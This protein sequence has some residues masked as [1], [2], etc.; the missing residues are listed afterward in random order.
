MNYLSKISLG[1]IVLLSACFPK[2]EAIEPKPRVNIS[3]ELDAGDNKNTVAFYSLDDAKV[4]AEADPMDWDFYIDE[5]VI[6]LNYFRSLRAAKFD[7]SFNQFDDTIGLDFRFL[8]SDNYDSMGQWELSEDQIYII[9]YG[10]DNDFNPMGLIAVS[11]TRDGSNVEIT[12]YEMGSD[13]EL[14]ET[15]SK[16]SFYYNLRD[17]KSIDLPK[18][19]EYNVAFGKYTDV[20][21]AENVTQDYLIYG[22]ILGESLAY[23]E[24]A[25]F[26]IVE[27]AT[28]DILRLTGEKNTIGWD[29]KSFNLAKGAYDIVPDKTYLISSNSSFKYKLRFVSFYNSSG[30]SGHPT[31]EFKLL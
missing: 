10:F 7:K 25:A 8:T 1:C 6:R 11:F 28:F 26:D 24:N 3:V 5:K 31:F 17:K 23:T 19:S 16:S 22:A 4:I 12:Y 14:T 30:V 13:F 20:V 2:E 18:E 21:T 27:D 9:D 29:W 15:I